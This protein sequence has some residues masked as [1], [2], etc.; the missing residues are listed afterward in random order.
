MQDIS[1]CMCTSPEGILKFDISIHVDSNVWKAKG[2][3]EM[4][5]EVGWVGSI[6]FTPSSPLLVQSKHD[7]HNIIPVSGDATCNNDTSDT[8]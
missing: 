5:E 1:I 8:V 6:T 4:N 3:V 7:P 2:G